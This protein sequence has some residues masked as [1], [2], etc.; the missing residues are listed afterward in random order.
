MHTA[1]QSKEQKEGKIQNETAECGSKGSVT[2]IIM[3]AVDSQG[4][5]LS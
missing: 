5:L 1:I 3:A 4:E 2:K